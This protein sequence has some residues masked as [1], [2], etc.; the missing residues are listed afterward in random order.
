MT[1]DKE[2]DKPK[3][4][5]FHG[6]K[7]ELIKYGREKGRLTWPEIR[8]ALPP[9]HLSGTELEV[10]LFTCKNMGIEIRE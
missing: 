5:D 1:K 6:R 10:L 9:E 3:S 4:T 2:F 8:K 7:R